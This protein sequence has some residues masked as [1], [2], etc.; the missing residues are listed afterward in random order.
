MRKEDEKNVYGENHVV[1]GVASNDHT[2]EQDTGTDLDRER[3]KGKKREVP[4]GGMGRSG[5]PKEERYSFELA[6]EP[7]TPRD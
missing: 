7:E 2:V 6:G 4:S 3:E 1:D 5:T